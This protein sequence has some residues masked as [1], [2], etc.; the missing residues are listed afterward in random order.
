MSNALAI[1]TVTTALADTVRTAV[2]GAVPGADVVTGR[3]D[4]TTAAGTPQRRV[5]L[6]LYQVAPNAALSNADLPMRGADR[7]FVQRPRAAL[8]LD[9]LLAFYGD[10]AQLEPQRM[11]G[12]V[13]RDLH[14]HPVL[15]RKAVANA[16]RS[17]PF[18][19]ASNLA[20][21]VEPVRFTPVPLTLEELSKLWSVFFQ[22][23]YA[24]TVTYRGT[25]VVIDGDETAT[26]PLPVRERII[27]VRPFRHPTIEE[28]QSADGPH[29]PI[30][31][32][33]TLVITGRH[34]RS[35]K[36]QVRVGGDL[37]EATEV[38]DTRVTLP[39]TSIPAK[40]LRAGVQAIQI[41]QPIMLGRPPKPHVGVESNVAAF[42]LRPKITPQQ[43][44]LAAVT[45]KIDP[46][47]A[48]AQRVVLLLNERAEHDSLA[49]SFVAPQGDKDTDAVTVPIK[50][51]KP[52][53][54]WVRVQVD[55]A[56]SLLDTDPESP[57]RGPEVEI[58]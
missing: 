46:P 35:D 22:T 34:L 24:L 18:L 3:P 14:A 43:A 23:P 5:H 28:V 56:E 57:K 20:E 47:V 44:T 49:Y 37:V 55:G 36:V 53:R 54:Y 21:E 17:Q 27:Y 13:V 10:D 42:V 15:T 32:G 19:A 8:D 33:G 41:V 29:A 25:V 48:P 39:L 52:A 7:R 38:T 45:I 11:L 30:M 40:A 12:A 4:A 2:Q 6:F 26:P 16:A 58:R 51:V 1:A 31:V 9:Y 50:G